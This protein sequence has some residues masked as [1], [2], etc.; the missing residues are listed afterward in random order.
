MNKDTNYMEYGGF[1]TSKAEFDELMEICMQDFYKT[2]NG[3]KISNYYSGGY[4]GYQVTTGPATEKEVQ[5]LRDLINNSK[6]HESGY[7]GVKY[8][9]EDD[10]QE[11]FD[12]KRSLDDTVRIIQDRMQKYVNENR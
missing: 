12:G 11:Y 9:I 5:L 2:E 8:I 1:P 3:D 6:A 7:G 10:I 4:S